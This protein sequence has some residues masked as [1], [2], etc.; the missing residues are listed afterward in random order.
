MK[1]SVRIMH[2]LCRLEKVDMGEKAKNK[3][4]FLVSL[5]QYNLSSVEVTALDG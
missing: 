1:I 2:C 4:A 3:S 5:C